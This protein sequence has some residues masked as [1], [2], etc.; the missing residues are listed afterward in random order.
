VCRDYALDKLSGKSRARIR[1]AAGSLEVRP[2]TPSWLAKF[3]HACHVEFSALK[4]M[5]PQSATEFEKYF[6]DLERHPVFECWTCTNGNELVGYAV[7]L[8]EHDGVFMEIFQITPAGRRSFAGYLLLHTILQH[9]VNDLS[10]PIS[11][12]TRSV[13]HPTDMQEFLLKFGFRREFA[14]LLIVYRPAVAV[15]VKMLFPFRKIFEW[16][17]RIPL[18][19]KISAVLQQEEIVRTQYAAR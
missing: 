10:L 17:D 15:L 16:F 11:N 18:S 1:R 12:G 4:N 9:Y 7:C 2:A 3:G 5:R 6:A 14:D 19:Q 8:R 13:L